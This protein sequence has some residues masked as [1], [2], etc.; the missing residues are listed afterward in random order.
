MGF[1]PGGKNDWK[2]CREDF[3][4]NAKERRRKAH[5]LWI[6]EWYV[7]AA[8]APA[9]SFQIHQL[10]KPDGRKGSGL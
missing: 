3:C 1:Y 4:A 5:V 2:E 7:R 6:Y 9:W 8:A 10:G